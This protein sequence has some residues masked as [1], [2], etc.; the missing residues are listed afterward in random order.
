M[1][2]CIWIFVALTRGSPFLKVGRQFILGPAV[3]VGV[4]NISLL[5]WRGVM[6]VICILSGISRSSGSIP[7]NCKIHI[8]ELEAYAT[9]MCLGRWAGFSDTFAAEKKN[10]LPGMISNMP[11]A[12]KDHRLLARSVVVSTNINR[13]R[14]EKTETAA[15][16]SAGIIIGCK[17][18]KNKNS[19]SSWFSSPSNGWWSLSRNS[20]PGNKDLIFDDYIR[21]TTY[22]KCH[23]T[24][25]PSIR[26]IPRMYLS[27]NEVLVSMST[28][29]LLITPN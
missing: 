19:Y 26:I 9:I 22:C 13:S 8:S 23:R 1:Q 4:F 29:R 14:I 12:A 27:M 25:F 18:L 7:W 20:T 28:V 5:A 17:T 6:S 11:R 3:S 16:V 24:I 15:W 2:C 10:G 21:L